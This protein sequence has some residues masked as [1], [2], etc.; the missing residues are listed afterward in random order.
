M[1]GRRAFYNLPLKPMNTPSLEPCLVKSLPFTHLKI[2]V[3]SHNFLKTML[4][5]ADY[6]IEN[7]VEEIIIIDDN[8]RIKA[9]KNILMANKIQVSI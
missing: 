2:F 1:K 8:R 5:I 7:R 9:A 3:T 6:F 4:R